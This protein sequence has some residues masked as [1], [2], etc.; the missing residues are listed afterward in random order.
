MGQGLG[1]RRRSGGTP[2]HSRLILILPLFSSQVTVK[3]FLFSRGRPELVGEVMPPPVEG[4]AWLVG[5][6]AKQVGNLG[7]SPPGET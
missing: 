6:A 3:N 1:G 4:A 2:A 7:M 5:E